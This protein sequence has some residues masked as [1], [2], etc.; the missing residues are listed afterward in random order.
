MRRNEANLT[1]EASVATVD[2][3]E[4]LDAA[5]GLGGDGIAC[6]ETGDAT[7]P[8]QSTDLECE[9]QAEVVEK[10]PRGFGDCD[11]IQ[12]CCGRQGK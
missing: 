7:T 1:E 2:E 5:G 4:R 8:H 12:P 9:T 6:E 3:F 11:T 10:A